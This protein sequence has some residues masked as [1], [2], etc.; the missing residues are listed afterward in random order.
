MRVAIQQPEHA[1]WLGFFDKM[2]TCDLFVYLDNVQYKKRYFENRN[3]I[4]VGDCFRWVTVPVVSKGRF[5]QK[6]NEVEID[7]SVKW[8]QKYVGNVQAAY[9]KTSYFKKY[10]PDVEKVV[11]QDYGLLLDL[12][13]ALVD[14]VRRWAGIDTPC[15]LASEILPE[16]SVTGSELILALCEK[17]DATE[18]VSGPDGRNYLDLSAFESVSIGVD[19]HDYVHPEYEQLHEG[20]ESHMSVL[21]VFFNMGSLP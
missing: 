6:I 20:F 16:T 4:R 8:Q 18:Y 17:V 3:K 5:S 7:N 21:D 13:L 14:M 2:K 9:S 15:R 19:Y 12:N 1:P 10:F 11:N